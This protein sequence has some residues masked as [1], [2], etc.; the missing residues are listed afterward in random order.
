MIWQQQIQNKWEKHQEQKIFRNI[1]L[2]KV[3]NAVILNTVK[4]LR[5]MN[6]EE[7]AFICSFISKLDIKY[8]I[9]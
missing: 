1:S 8:L 5:N 4:H 9:V 6:N 2:T 3:V 7:K